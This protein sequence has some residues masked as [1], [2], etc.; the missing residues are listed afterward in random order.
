MPHHELGL[1]FAPVT[2]NLYIYQGTNNTQNSLQK[3]QIPAAFS[4]WIA[5]L[6]SL[7]DT[8]FSLW[9]LSSVFKKIY[10][11]RWKLFRIY[12]L[13]HSQNCKLFC[14]SQFLIYHTL[15]SLYRS[16]IM[17][18]KFIYYLY[19]SI[20][21]NLLLTEKYLESL[22]FWFLE[23]WFLSFNCW[24]SSGPMLV[25]C[26]WEQIAVCHHLLTNRINE[27]ALPPPLSTG[28]VKVSSVKPKP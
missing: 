26:L 13:P 14:F 23:Q 9:Q 19:A 11:I 8:F 12:Y 25:L 7:C 3:P 21:L 20:S 2:L 10:S 15:P 24:V 18:L 16:R 22:F 5:C 17:F 1:G 28:L 6:L 4:E 27:V